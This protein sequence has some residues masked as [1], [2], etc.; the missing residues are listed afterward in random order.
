[1]KTYYKH[2]VFCIF[3]FIGLVLLLMWNYKLIERFTNLNSTKTTTVDLP[4][5]TPYTCNNWCGPTA[6][7]AITGEQCL[8]DTDCP[9]CNI[10]QPNETTK[11]SHNVLGEN[12][13]GKLNYLTPQFSSLTT[14]IGTQSKRINYQHDLK[15]LNGNFGINTWMNSFKKDMQEFNKRYKPNNVMPY[16]ATYN[17]KYTLSGIFIEDGPLASNAYFS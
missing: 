2:K 7:C 13:A 5:N 16:G 10:P 12:D 17:P 15:P 14:D 9:G 4:L 3:T 6:R 1:M 8:A 11:L